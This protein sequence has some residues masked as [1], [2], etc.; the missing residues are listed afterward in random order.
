MSMLKYKLYEDENVDQGQ[1]PEKTP[2][3]NNRLYT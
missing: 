3:Q 1:D 2:N